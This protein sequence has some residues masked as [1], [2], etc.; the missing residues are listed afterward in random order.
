[1]RVSI[2]GL[3]YCPEPTG[4][5]P[6]T[7]GLAEHLVQQGHDVHVVTG[8]PHYPS[9]HIDPRYAGRSLSETVNGVPVDRVRHFVPHSMTVAQRTRLEISF[10]ARAVTTAGF[11]DVMRS[12]V[13]VCVSPAL[14]S[15]GMVMARLRIR[16]RR[17][18]IGIWVQDLYSRGV[19]ETGMMDG[20]GVGLVDRVESAVLRRADGLAVLHPRFADHV[21]DNLEVDR[22]A[23]AVIPNWNHLPPQ[24]QVDRAEARRQLGWPADRVIA[25]HAGNM[26]LKQ[27]LENVVQAAQL[28]DRISAGVTFVL[29]G[30]GNQREKLERLG[31][32]TDTLEFVR[33]LPEETFVR[34]LA[35]ADV[36]IVNEGTD[37]AE[38]AV[39]SKLTSYFGSGR[40]VVAATRE[41]SV[42]AHEVDRSGAGVRVD[43]GE[44]DELLRTVLDLAADAD[45]SATLGSA[46]AAHLRTDMDRAT[47]LERF[48]AWIE[49][50][51]RDRQL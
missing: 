47:A 15:T 38:M 4:I 30:D 42:T 5:A 44:P 22:S 7:A 11:R 17:P 37:I 12:D 41:G 27:G 46:G 43:P 45:R 33:P 25:L 32:G 1:M 20:R 28:S 26:G 9:W 50:L 13:V 6:Y 49:R 16:K 10:G 40:P 51:A 8:Y 36:L 18:A 2:V 19:A 3:N 21:A 23:V 29:L 48:D 14:I 31:A 24:R 35:A 39:P 34:A